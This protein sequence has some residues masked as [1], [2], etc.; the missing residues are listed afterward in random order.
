MLKI[1]IWIIKSKS[2]L[3]DCKIMLCKTINNLIVII[4]CVI[5]FKYAVRQILIL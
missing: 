2:K 4:Y 3:I 1:N 5:F